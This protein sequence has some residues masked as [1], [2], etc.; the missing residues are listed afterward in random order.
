[1]ILVSHA[2]RSAYG[3][4]HIINVLNVAERFA[5]DRDAMSHAL[6]CYRVAMCV[7]VFVAIFVPNYAEFAMRLS[8]ARVRVEQCSLNLLTVVMWLKL[9]NWTNGWTEEIKPTHRLE[10]TMPKSDIKFARSAELQF[11]TVV[12]M[13]N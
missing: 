11:C 6:G 5:T 1:M 9:G 10:M 13:E 7:S 8:S 4:V 12:G 3:S 2:L